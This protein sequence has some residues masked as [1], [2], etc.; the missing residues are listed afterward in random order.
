MSLP[1]N[2]LVEKYF[3]LPQ[4]TQQHTLY[5]IITKSSYKELQQIHRLVNDLLSIDILSL[6]PQS[7]ALRV[8]SYLD[9]QSLCRASKVNRKWHE[10]AINDGLWYLLCR[11][12]DWLGYGE[13]N[14][15]IRSVPSTPVSAH[16]PPHISFLIELMQ[17]AKNIHISRWKEV[18]IRAHLLN[19]NWRRGYYSVLPSLKGHSR[20]VNAFDCLN[21]VVLSG[22]EDCSV[23][24]WSTSSLE[25]KFKLDGH[26]DSVN[27][28]KLVET[29]AFGNDISTIAL[30]GCSD[31][32][33][34]VYNTCNG[35]LLRAV[36]SQMTG[37]DS[38]SSIELLDYNAE[39]IVGC[40]DD[41]CVR[42][43]GLF[44]DCKL[45]HY[46]P[47][48]RDE[49]QQVKVSGNIAITCSWDA[50]M[51]VWNVAKGFCLQTLSTDGDPI[52]CCSIGEGLI[53][54][55][56]AEGHVRVWHAN[57]LHHLFTM[58]G[59]NGEV[60]CVGLNSDV[61]LSGGADSRV[62]MYTRSGVEAGVFPGVH[63]GIV[64]CLKMQSHRAITSGD[65]KMVAVWD[66]RNRS[67]LN[68]IHR[69]P[70]LV[71]DIWCDETRIITASPDTPGVITIISFW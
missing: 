44:E 3:S 54:G 45:I 37:V 66:T 1:D 57:T 4:T 33:L 2:N 39:Y 6:L 31:G 65:R 16:R 5:T 35:Y 11:E 18:F 29:N 7:D 9:A 56:G 38:Y 61:I 64:R 19:R 43:W 8:L 51:R 47:G 48:H 63:I 53:L 23:C 49:I 12:E 70:S 27:C 24:L 62:C 32:F 42:V 25:C 52:M 21:G 41:F 20:R 26:S 17:D 59:H 13:E 58:S 28:V 15:V 10:L 69:N 60:Y 40:G 68:V 55:G 34:R 14:S 50:T 22:A 36:S 30:T 46:L 71:F 67:L